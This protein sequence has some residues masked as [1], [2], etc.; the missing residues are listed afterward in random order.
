VTDGVWAVGDVTGVL[1]FTHV[2]KYQGRI[3]A[4]DILGREARADYRAVPR[5]VFT[6]PQVAAVGTAD[7]ERRGTGRLADVPRAFTYEHPVERP[8]FL[9]LVAD[10]DALVG[11]FAVGPEAG[12]WIGQATVAIRARVPL[13]ILRDVIQPF[14]TFSEIFVKALDDLSGP[15]ADCPTSA[16]LAAATA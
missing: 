8:G 13:D 4:A 12:E 16:A 2:G 6:D 9:T 7:G 3:A 14:P 15:I 11:A 10:G 1:M 5:V